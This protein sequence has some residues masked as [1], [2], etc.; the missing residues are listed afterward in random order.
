MDSHVIKNELQEIVKEMMKKEIVTP[1]ASIEI[2]DTGMI[3]VTL[4]GDSVDPTCLINPKMKII[5]GD[6][7]V[8]SLTNAM[9]YATKMQGMKERNEAQLRRKTANLIDFAKSIGA[10]AYFLNPLEEMMERLSSN[11]ITHQPDDDG[12]SF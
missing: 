11:I 6:T 10:E 2:F 9:N 7:I 3:A 4:K 5:R 8:K 12:V 1:S